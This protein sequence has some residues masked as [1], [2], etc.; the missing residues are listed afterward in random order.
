MAVVWGGGRDKVAA[1]LK[2]LGHE[3]TF[4]DAINTMV[5]TCHYT[6]L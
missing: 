6:F 1:H 5:D 4:Y 3:T 2:L